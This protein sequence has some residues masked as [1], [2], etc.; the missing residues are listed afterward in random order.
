LGTKKTEHEHI[1]SHSACIA[2][3]SPREGQ[4]VSISE[5]K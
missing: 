5:H 1:R 2:K 3:Y 4:G